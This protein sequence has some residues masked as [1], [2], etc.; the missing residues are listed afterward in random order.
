MPPVWSN[1]TV[2]VWALFCFLFT[3][4]LA[5]TGSS[6][7]RILRTLTMIIQH[8]VTR[9]WGSRYLKFSR[10]SWR[11]TQY[12]QISRLETGSKIV[13]LHQVE[14]HF[15]LR[16]CNNY[17]SLYKL[18]HSNWSPDPLWNIA[19]NGSEQLWLKFGISRIYLG[20]SRRLGSRTRSDLSYE[21]PR[22]DLYSCD[23]LLSTL[24]GCPVIITVN[25]IR[26]GPSP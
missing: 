8:D 13:F 12:R 10:S 1:S 2:Y 17:Y 23:T 9:L 24:S 19:V 25:P 3:I 11:D 21:S 6:P 22:K 5:T 20:N 7:S 26:I 16:I 4:I 14:L 15:T 18:I